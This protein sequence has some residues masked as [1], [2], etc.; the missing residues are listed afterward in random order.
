MGYPIVAPAGTPYGPQVGFQTEQVFPPSAVYVGPDDAITLIV[1]TPLVG[2]PLQLS[3]RLLT[4]QGEIIS[5]H[6]D[7]QTAPT[8]NSFQSYRIPPSEG[9]LL[10]ASLFAPG[11]ARGQVFIQLF[12]QRGTDLVTPTLAALLCQ[13]YVSQFERLTY[14]FSPNEAVSSGRGFVKGVAF[15][16][17]P[18]GLP[19]TFS[20]PAGVNWRIKCIWYQLVTDATVGNRAVRVSFFLPGSIRAADVPM[21]T[22]VPGSTTMVCTWAE[23]VAT[24]GTDN[25]LQGCLPQDLLLPGTSQITLVCRSEGPNDVQT[26]IGVAVEEFVG[27]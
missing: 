12:L 9:F 25:V 17:G 18:V 1:R 10:S 13:G 22:T 27:P 21:S 23:N 24:V 15:G 7:Y 26:N 11:A 3:Y 8:G 2:F 20:V 14:P 6:D 16:N 5:N 19:F 4:P